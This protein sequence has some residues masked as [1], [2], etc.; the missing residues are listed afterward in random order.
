MNKWVSRG[1]VFEIFLS[2]QKIC[3]KSIRAPKLQSVNGTPFKNIGIELQSKNPGSNNLLKYIPKS[4][5][6]PERNREA[7]T[8]KY[9][10]C[11]RGCRP[12]AALILEAFGLKSCKVGF[13]GGKDCTSKSSYPLRS[14]ASRCHT[15]LYKYNTKKTSSLQ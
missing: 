10:K 9:Q 8:Q 5:M 6:F 12:D 14:L 2:F 15:H 13:P 11:M 1:Q 4:R 7:C 3:L